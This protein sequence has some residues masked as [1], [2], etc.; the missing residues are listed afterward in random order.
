MPLQAQPD[1]HGGR[2]GGR[3]PLAQ[4]AHDLDVQAALG[5]RTLHRP[6]REPVGQLRPAGGVGRQPFQ[7]GRAGVQHV[8]HQ[9]QSQSSIGTGQ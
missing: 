9:P 8:A 5:R 6:L 4:P 2:P 3:D 7:V 1:P